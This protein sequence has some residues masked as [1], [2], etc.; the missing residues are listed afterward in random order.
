VISYEVIRHKWELDRSILE[1]YMQT[2]R[3]IFSSTNVLSRS[4]VRQ[5]LSMIELDE[6]DV[7]G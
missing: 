1:E 6:S 7:F 2:R 5:I 4:D 3:K